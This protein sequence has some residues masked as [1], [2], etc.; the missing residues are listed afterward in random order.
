[1]T[2]GGGN[3]FQFVDQDT[4]TGNTTTIALGDTVH[5]SW[6]MGSH[7][8]TRDTGA[9]NWDSLVRGSGFTFDHQFN[10]AGKFVYWCTLHGSSTSGMRGFVVVQDSNAPTVSI[11]DL[12]HAE[13]DAG[14]TAFDFPVTLSHSAATDVTVHYSTAGGTAASGTDFQAVS[15]GIVTITAGQTTG[16]AEVMVEGD[17]TGELDEAFTV[18]LSSPSGATIAD[19]SATGTIQN[20]DGPPPTPTMSIADVTV[21]EGNGSTTPATFVVSL[22]NAVASNV[23]AHFQ[24]ADGTATAPS[25]YRAK[26]GTVTVPAGQTTSSIAVTVVGDLLKEP[27]E[28]FTVTLSAPSGATLADAQATGSIHDSTDACTIVGTA[29]SDTL[30][31]TAGRDTIC[32][33]GG[34]DTLSGRLGGDTLLGGPGNDTLRGGA[35]LDVLRGAAGNDTLHGTDGVSGN[36]TLSGGTGTDA[37]DADPGDHVTGCP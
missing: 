1:M 18:T 37:C 22:S 3:G 8:S 36:D 32:G 28:T 4:G 34:A 2:V 33:L 23:T 30:T 7:S 15:S 9:E 6:A 25:D 11:G 14:T 5:W 10:T 35:G 12:S 31:G 13:G 21:A 27:D 20:D 16:V 29:A 24:T 26:S 17:T 19:G